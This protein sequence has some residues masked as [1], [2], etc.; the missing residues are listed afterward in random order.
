MSLFI[1]NFHD[2]VYFVELQK[3]GKYLQIFTLLKCNAYG[4]IFRNDKLFPSQR[5]LGRKK[6]TTFKNYILF[7]NCANQIHVLFVITS[8]IYV[9]T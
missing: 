8:V 7:Y 3:K 1:L 6:C 2:K 9:I 4:H 5:D